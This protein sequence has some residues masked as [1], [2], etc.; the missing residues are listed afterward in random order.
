MALAVVQDVHQK[1]A[2]F[3][4]RRFGIR[5][6]DGILLLVSIHISVEDGG[7]LLVGAMRPDSNE[8][9]SWRDSRTPGEI[10]SILDMPSE[11]VWFSRLV[12]Q[13]VADLNRA[14]ADEASRADEDNLN[15]ESD[16]VSSGAP[17]ESREQSEQDQTQHDSRGGEVLA[18]PRKEAIRALFDQIDR[19]GSGSLTRRDII[20]AIR[21]DG[22]KK[23]QL[24]EILGFPDHIYQE[25]GTR[26][27]F[28]HV[29][30]EMDFDGSNDLSFEEFYEYIETT[31]FSQ[32]TEDGRL[33]ESEAKA[34]SNPRGPPPPVPSRGRNREATPRSQEGGP[35]ADE[36]RDFAQ[37]TE[38]PGKEAGLDKLIVRMMSDEDFT[39]TA[40]TD[41]SVRSRRF[42]DELAAVSKGRREDPRL[43]Q[44]V[45]VAKLRRLLD[46]PTRVF[47]AWAM[48]AN[49][50]SVEYVQPKAS[51]LSQERK[52]GKA[53]GPPRLMRWDS[54]EEN[55][56]GPDT[57]LSNINEL[58]KVHRGV[59]AANSDGRSDNIRSG[60]TADSIAV[61][62]HSPSTLKENLP[63]QFERSATVRLEQGR[64]VTKFH[65]H[66]HEELRLKKVSGCAVLMLRAESFDGSTVY[67][68]GAVV[69]DSAAHLGCQ[70]MEMLHHSFP[71][72]G[73]IIYSFW[74]VPT[75]LSSVS[76]FNQDRSAEQ[77]AFNA[78]LQCYFSI[79]STFSAA[80]CKV[81][82][83]KSSE[84]TSVANGAFI[85][86]ELGAKLP[87][88]FSPSEKYGQS[89]ARLPHAIAPPEG[90][91]QNQRTST[92][93]VHN[94]GAAP[95]L[96]HGHHV[97]RGDAVAARVYQRAAEVDHATA[98]HAAQNGMQ[99]Q[100]QAPHRNL[101]NGYVQRHMSTSWKP[102]PWQPV[103]VQQQP[104][105]EFLREQEYRKQNLVP[106]APSYFLGLNQQQGR[107]HLQQQGWQQQQQQ[108]QPFPQQQYVQQ[109]Q[110]QQQPLI[111]QDHLPIRQD[112]QQPP[113]QGYARQ[114]SLLSAIN[115]PFEVARQQRDAAPFVVY[116]PRQQHFS[117]A[118][119]M[120]RSNYG[121]GY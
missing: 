66:A 56:P 52:A 71:S 8:A 69:Y 92:L 40:T 31:R 87:K 58:N 82:P 99:A 85:L 90:I 26:D 5:S 2:A 11:D 112:Q 110:Q 74:T 20:V 68:D 4:G 9:V 44:R 48:L 75:E 76:F 103:A 55:I 47:G 19:V 97:N 32:L 91:R 27:V 114:S 70:E 7:Q 113:I 73:G 83:I 14:Y 53:K 101:I 116:P 111:R 118:P 38:H 10:M 109:Q 50:G 62:A 49:G 12:S 100:P 35:I 23:R 1:K 88:L 72:L 95:W 30:Q 63:M 105:N 41:Q 78:V 43:R 24:R 94:S 13:E 42:E 18:Q 84:E 107:F 46:V 96:P 106:S 37:N 45:A 33:R 67:A 28:E 59:E 21:R 77:D 120:Q 115:A 15:D 54:K 25:D 80:E 108:Q 36:E 98:A 17:S 34:H 51:E 60:S 79:V 102:T 65:L 93:R 29:F 86:G 61:E 16:G 119:R 64:P 6:E 117:D 81:S 104:P 22:E 3:R 121:E 57:P 39:H 89:P